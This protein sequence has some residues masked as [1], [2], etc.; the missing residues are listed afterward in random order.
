MEKNIKD[1][2]ESHGIMYFPL[3]SDS[4]EKIYNLYINKIVPVNI[5]CLTGTE[6]SRCATYY[7][8]QENIELMLKYLF[9]A[10][11]KNDLLAMSNL[12]NYYRKQ[13]DVENA[14]KYYKM[15][16]D[17]GNNIAM[18]N[19]ISLYQHIE[20]FENMIKYCKMVIDDNTFSN[21]KL[22]DQYKGDDNYDQMLV[23]I[24]EMNIILY[25][26]AI[27]C[28]VSYFYTTGDY[29]QMIKYLLLSIEHGDDVSMNNLGA[30]YYEIGN[31]EQ[32]EKYL[33]L[34]INEGYKPAMINYA[35]YHKNITKNNEL[36]QIYFKMAAATI[37]N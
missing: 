30:Y 27:Q 32:M 29:D 23:V 2:V 10:V 21:I 35:N 8:I 24:K 37:D 11:N 34:S 36:A 25:F 6:L 18:N 19:L 14:V 3:P 9:M 22:I 1:Y 31:Y 4:I 28:L 13:N 17:K 15:S 33:L 12:G 26:N 7:L 5:E 20:D 16:I